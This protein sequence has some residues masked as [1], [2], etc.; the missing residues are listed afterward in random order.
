MLEPPKNME[1]GLPFAGGIRSKIREILLY[2]ERSRLIPGNGIRLTE[3]P[4]G[5]SVSAEVKKTSSGVAP[6]RNSQGVL[7]Y[8][9]PWGLYIELGMIRVKPGLVWTPDG[10]RCYAPNPCERPAVPSLIVLTVANGPL[11]FTIE[12]EID[13]HG[14]GLDYWNSHALL[15]R[16]DPATDS[17][18]QYHFS[19]I[20]FMLETEDLIIAP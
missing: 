17:V 16:Y 7:E 9:G 20:V 18:T 6:R 4:C 12:G 8:A 11:L 15:G 5:I 13:R 2:L 14:L 1:P 19:P 10:A 3:T